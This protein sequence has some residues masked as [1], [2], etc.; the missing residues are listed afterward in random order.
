MKLALLKTCF[1]VF[2]HLLVHKD[3]FAIAGELYSNKHYQESI[4]ICTAQLKKLD[5]KDTLYEKFLLLRSGS[6]L[7]LHDFRSG[8]MDYLTLVKIKPREI[9]YYINLS[10]MYGEVEQFDNC[11]GVLRSAYKINPVD[12][13]VLV[14]LAYYSGQA[15]KYYDAISYADEGLK[16]NFD[17]NPGFK[18][19]MINNRGF[20]YMGLKKYTEAL[21][22]INEAI[23][24]DPGNSYAWCYRAM[25]NI[26]LKKFETVCTDLQKSKELGG[27]VMTE[28]LI[29]KYC[30]V[31]KM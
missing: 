5:M 25:A 21:N 1:W 14:N 30:T 31:Q 2:S 20:G 10:Y 3:T 29:Q 18:S 24:L 12:T 22:D 19:S 16:L 8:I 13:V 7:E 9:P 23:K 27:V 15:G 11:L 17:T 4:E 26:R 28:A 6:Y